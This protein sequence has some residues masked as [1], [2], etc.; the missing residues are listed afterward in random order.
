MKKIAIATMLVLAAGAASAGDWY[1]GVSLDQKEKQAT[2]ASTEYHNVFAMTIGKKLGDGYSVESLIEDEQVRG[3]AGD[4][5]KTK[6]KHEGLFQL[7]G[8]K[9][10][11]TGT[12]FTPYAGIAAGMKSKTASSTVY[13]GSLDFPFYRYDLG[14]KAKLN[15][16]LSV[17]L[18]W[19]HRQALNDTYD[20][21]ST[22]WNTNETTLALGIKLTDVD[23][24]SV[25][26]K[27]ERSN[28]SSKGSTNG[29][30]ITEYNTTAI[31]YTRAF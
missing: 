4:Q 5:P 29:G 26:Y 18:G 20:G 27:I 12:M 24:I 6:G 16:M 17:R 28:D 8:N 3:V 30:S 21:Q 2:S 15:D 19:R 23:T 22:N 7:R 9:D 1:G 25:A 14:V 11:D 10:F 13:G 31:S